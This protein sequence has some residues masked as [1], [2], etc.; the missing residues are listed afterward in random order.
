MNPQ[1]P[2]ELISAYFDGE[3]SP[4]E[5]VVVEQLLADSDDAQR[6]LNETAR[7]SALLH[8]FPRES[9]PVDLVSNVLRQTEQLPLPARANS[10]FRASR[11]VSRELIAGLISAALTAAGILIC[12]G[13]V[14]SYRGT[15]TDPI[16]MEHAARSPSDSPMAMR[17]LP[18]SEKPETETLASTQDMAIQDVPGIDARGRNQTGALSESIQNHEPIRK[19]ASNPEVVD[20]KSEALNSM[21]KQP[22]SLEA[23]RPGQGPLAN[24]SRLAARSAGREAQQIETNQL[25]L[26][27]ED[28]VEGLR[29]GKVYTFV[30]QPADPN[31]NVPVVDVVVV[32]IERGLEKIQVL[33]KKNSI[34]PRSVNDANEGTPDDMVVLYVVAPGDLL[35]KTLKDMQNEKE[36]REW[37][38]QPPLQVPAVTDDSTEFAKKDSGSNSKGRRAVNTQP[39]L[40]EQETE[41][42]DAQQ[43]IDAYAVRNGLV[44]SNTTSLIGNNIDGT[45]AEPMVAN[46]AQQKARG[47][48]T[49]QRVLAANNNSDQLSQSYEL[50][51]LNTSIANGTVQSMNSGAQVNSIAPIRPDNLRAQRKLVYSGQPNDKAVANADASNRALR[52]LFVLHPQHDSNSALPAGPAIRSGQN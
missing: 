23:D 24:D 37:N 26:S 35:A 7:L 43:V 48:S 46:K 51:R 44:T 13:V 20:M 27:N 2:D 19:A 6:E 21:Q 33:L 32:D 9:A 45:R 49:E 4:E 38:S 41:I 34:G 52:L 14:D 22:K 47:N 12:W 30:P 15:L 17:N 42:P 5:R 11:N 36:F 25:G 16:A 3:V 10:V 18:S 39:L 31:S 50:R 29:E 8:S 40:A 28:F 1:V